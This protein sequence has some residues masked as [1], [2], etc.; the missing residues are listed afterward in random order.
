MIW[1]CLQLLGPLPPSADTGTTFLR[2]FIG[3]ARIS[4]LKL[5]RHRKQES[6]VFLRFDI[7]QNSLIE[8]E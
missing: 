8:D 7:T 1:I 3:L 2:P 4:S 6:T 5:P